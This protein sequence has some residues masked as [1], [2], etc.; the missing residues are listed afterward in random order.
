MNLPNKITL[1]RLICV[2]FID[3]L[4]LIP[5]N[6]FTNLVII[7]GLNVDIIF[8]IAFILFALASFSDFLD[9]HIARKYDLVTNFGRFMDPIADKLLVNSLF[10]ILTQYGPIKIPVIIPVIMI[11]RDII[12]D[13]M[14]MLAVE[15]GKV[16]AANIFGKI[17]TVLQMIAL[18]FVLLNDFPFA[19]LNLDYPICLIICWLAMIAS[20]VS[21]VIYI[22]QNKNLIK[23]TK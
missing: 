18:I 12:V 19:Y 4:I 6:K 5:W 8:F 14:R 23:E 16:V 9:G 17:K 15:Q 2:I 3:A 7:P 10:I 13:V 22:I 1:F 11:A 21:G 20:L